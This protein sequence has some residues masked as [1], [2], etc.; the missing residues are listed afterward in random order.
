MYIVLP[1]LLGNK[2]NNVK[3][4]LN[5]YI[6]LFNICSVFAL[7]GT[8]SQATFPINLIQNK[9]SQLREALGSSE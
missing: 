4:Q 9:A 2:L 5:K 7:Q 3:Y 1:N 6:F 8:R